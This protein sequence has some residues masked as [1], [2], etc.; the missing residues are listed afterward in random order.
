MGKVTADGVLFTM[1]DMERGHAVAMTV[2]QN[3]GPAAILSLQLVAGMAVREGIDTNA[4]LGG[5]IVSLMTLA[6]Q[7]D[8]SDYRTPASMKNLGAYWNMMADRH[9]EQPNRLTVEEIDAM[10]NKEGGN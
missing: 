3:S 5:F 8:E 2:L 1:E 4:Q 10:H 6:E 9:T 7:L